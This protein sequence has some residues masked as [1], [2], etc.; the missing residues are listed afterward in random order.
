MRGTTASRWTFIIDKEG[1]IAYKNEQV[2]AAK[3][4]EMVLE[5]LNEGKNKFRVTSLKF[6]ARLND[7]ISHV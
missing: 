7:D 5:F 3:D 6:K 1:K 4:A 2:D